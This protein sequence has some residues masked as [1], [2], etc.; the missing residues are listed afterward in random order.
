MKIRKLVKPKVRRG[1]RK[2]AKRFKKSL[3]FMGVNAAG[4]K[5]K[6][7]SFKKVLSDLRLSVFLIEETKYKE[8]GHLKVGNDFV[9][10]ELVRKSENGGGGLALGCL[11]DLNPCWVSEGNDQVEALS[12]DIFLKNIKIRC[13]VAYGPQESDNVEKKEAFWEH[14]DKEVEEACKAGA[15]FVLQFDG[16][17]WAGDNVIPAD[18]RPQNKNGKLFVEFL[19]RNPNLTVVNSL[20]LCQGLITR[21]RVKDGVVEESV[22]DFFIVCSLVLPHITKMVIDDSKSH[23][24]TNYKQV[25]KSGKAIDS[26]HFTEYLDMDLEVIKEKPER[27]ELFNFKDK[28]CQEKFTIL[29]SETKEFTECFRGKKPL[30]KKIDNW[31]K[32]LN[33]HCS[34]AFNKIRIKKNGMK[35]ISKRLS[36]LIDKRNKLVKEDASEKE[37]DETNVSIADTEAAENR[38]K[39]LK[40]FQY[41]SEN[42]ESIDM[43]KMWKSLKEIC[44]K[45]KPILPSAKQNFKGKI[46]SGKKEIKNLLA[47]E[48]K[49]RLRTRPYRHDYLATGRRRKR[50]FELKLNLAKLKKT[51]PWTLKDLESALCDLKRNKSRDFEGLLNEIFKMDVIGSNLKDSLLIMFNNLKLEGLISEFMNFANITT[52]PKK[53]PKI[54]LKNERG[55][56]RVS[57]V[58]YILMRMVY[59][60]KYPIIDKNISDFQMG[61][62]KGKGCRSNI[63][64]I[65]G[66]IHETLHNKKKK[67]IV[68]QIYD[69]AQMFDSINLQE[70]LSDIYDYGLDDD[71][72]SLI[73][74]ANKEVHM[75]VKTPGGLTDRQVLKNLVLQGDTWG[76]ILASVQVDTIAKDVEEA[77]LGYLYKE[78]LPV[79]ILGLVDDMLGVSEVGFKAQQMNVVLNV[80]S[81]EKGLQ[82]GVK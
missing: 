22:L 59:N 38:E 30:L 54:L 27:Q 79:S 70:A 12:V 24:L 72:L 31:R 2:S 29:T 35:R 39:V 58:R 51:P 3:R 65:N 73:H 78:S 47:N 45:V 21:S 23:I 56:F 74:L 81:A 11:K 14:L 44:P 28:Q 55:I 64:I 5:S 66:I 8:T 13:C 43:Q 17:L 50:I 46:I 76:S 19:E 61:G 10:Y 40:H 20:S 80:K 34:N 48:Y 36:S 53:G 6:L 67:P 26:D 15:G 62:R 9:I 57:V 71:N 7:A 63:W 18:P 69:Y 77:D 68:L 1:K 52:V 37:I 16:N 41:F 25:R 42:P 82:F 4:L 75:S 32:V 33:S 60:S 49:N